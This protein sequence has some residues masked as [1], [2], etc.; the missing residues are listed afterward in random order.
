[1]RVELRKSEL[2]EQI[3][4]LEAQERVGKE[5]PRASEAERFAAWGYQVLAVQYS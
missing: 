1:M 2:R 5:K 3:L 4:L